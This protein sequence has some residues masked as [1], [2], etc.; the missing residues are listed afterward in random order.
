MVKKSG[1]SDKRQVRS[2]KTEKG[3][4]DQVGLF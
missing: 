2:E 4:A 1:I 3:E